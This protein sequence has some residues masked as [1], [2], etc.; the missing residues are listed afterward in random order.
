MDCVEQ[1]EEPEQLLAA[2]KGAKWQ[3]RALKVG[4]KGGL[5]AEGSPREFE[6]AWG[7]TLQGRRWRII[8]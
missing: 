8:A 2:L 1:S 7:G 3:Q 4:R 6:G 5:A